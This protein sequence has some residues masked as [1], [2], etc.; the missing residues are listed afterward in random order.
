MTLPQTSRRQSTERSPSSG[1]T[2]QAPQKA[3]HWLAA[4]CGWPQSNGASATSTYASASRATP[5]EMLRRVAPDLSA[6][7]VCADQENSLGASRG[8]PEAL[9]G[10]AL[11]APVLLTD[12]ARISQLEPGLRDA[13]LP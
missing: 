5:V 10:V 7:A 12:T 6:L 11:R 8:A 3:K 13:V 1:P 9:S 4:S 2:G